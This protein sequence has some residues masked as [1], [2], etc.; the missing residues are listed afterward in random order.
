MR[1]SEKSTMKTSNEMSRRVQAALFPVS[2]AL[3]LS[4]VLR[5]CGIAHKHFLIHR[6]HTHMR[7]APRADRNHITNQAFASCSS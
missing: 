5:C 3:S 4:L 2:L 1:Y 6:V 7:C